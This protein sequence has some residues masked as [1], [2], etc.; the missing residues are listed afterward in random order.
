MFPA[1]TGAA[2]G[3]PLEVWA[4][5][6]AVGLEDEDGRRGAERVAE[7]YTLCFAHPAVCA[8][9]RDGEGLLRPDGARRT[10]LRYLHKLIDT[11]W[12]SRASGE[13]DANGRFRWRGFLG[14]Y[15]VAARLGEAAA[16]TARFALRAEGSVFVLSLPEER[17]S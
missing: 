3:A 4:R 7:L 1:D 16:T 5:G 12:H 14:D 10:A 13:T 15:R 17:S 6:G 2:A 9:T 11:V 8:I